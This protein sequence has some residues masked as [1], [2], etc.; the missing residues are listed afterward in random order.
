MW[1]APYIGLPYRQ[2]HCWEL[3]RRIFAEQ[4]GILLHPF[5]EIDP[6]DLRRVAREMGAGAQD[7]T[8]VETPEPFD[9]VVMRRHRLPI[10]V[11]IVTQPGWVLHTERETDAVHVPL[12]HVTVAGRIVGFRRWPNEHPGSLS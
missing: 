1:W 12:D 8:P 11:G 4:R 9:V 2:A 10:H 6:N 5:A 7:W 3:V